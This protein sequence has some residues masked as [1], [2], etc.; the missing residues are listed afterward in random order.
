MV[1]GK[2]YFLQTSTHHCQKRRFR[3]GGEK[4]ERDRVRER[5]GDIITEPRNGLR[6]RE[7]VVM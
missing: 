7:N 2:P 5:F 4:R 6:E 1:V 3:E